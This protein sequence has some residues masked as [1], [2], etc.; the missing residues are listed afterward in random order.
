MEVAGIEYFRIV[1]AWRVEDMGV[2]RVCLG[3]GLTY[4]TY[5]GNEEIAGLSW[6]CPL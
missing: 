3:R 5:H 6:P 4:T 2:D 1:C